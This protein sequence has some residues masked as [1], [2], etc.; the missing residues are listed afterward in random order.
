MNAQDLNHKQ[1]R[2]T[3]QK[4]Y[5]KLESI[6]D[7]AVE[8]MHRKKI[9]YYATDRIYSEDSRKL[10]AR[11]SFK[12]KAWAKPVSSEDIKTEVIQLAKENVI[13]ISDTILNDDPSMIA[14]LELV[15]EDNIEMVEEVNEPELVEQPVVA[16]EE[17]PVVEAVR[18]KDLVEP[19]EVNEEAKVVSIPDY[20][21]S[22]EA[23][24]LAD[25]ISE[26]PEIETEQPEVKP[27]IEEEKKVEPK[28][29]NIYQYYQKI[30]AQFGKKESAEVSQEETL[31]NEESATEKTGVGEQ[32]EL[33]P[34]ESTDKAEIIEEV[35]QSPDE[36]KLSEAVET[37]NVAEESGDYLEADYDRFLEF[38]NQILEDDQIPDDMTLGELLAS[39][40][41]DDSYLQ[42]DETVKEQV[43]EEE[44]FSETETYETELE[45]VEEQAITI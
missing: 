30:K 15:G 20:E 3:Y 42:R 2:L 33:E 44:V 34:E 12:E 13:P 25:L 43:A 5:T 45:P 28:R 39:I 9:I 37:E 11:E 27:A 14:F 35:E 22:A 41:E 8:R 24:I 40:Q 21:D 31:I 23:V 4:D 19:E 16:E 29:G 7:A 6:F 10:R 38:S 32:L 26:E 36:L 1:N 18:L 17:P